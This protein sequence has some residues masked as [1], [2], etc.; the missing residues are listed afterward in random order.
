M[1]KRVHSLTMIMIL[2]CVVATIS[3]SP[4]SRHTA[5]AEISTEVNVYEAPE[6]YE[7]TN[8]ISVSLSISGGR[9]NCSG[10]VKPLSAGLLKQPSA[11]KEL[12]NAFIQG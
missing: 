10:Y 5:N 3:T 7:Y 6:R 12:D 11:I 9:A 1:H 2:P 8:T 4:G